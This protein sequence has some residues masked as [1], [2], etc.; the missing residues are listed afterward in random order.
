MAEKEVSQMFRELNLDSDPKDI[1]IG[2]FKE[3][4]YG[5]GRYGVKGRHK[6]EL[7]SA[8]ADS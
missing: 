4:V 5:S 3:F 6:K 8:S 2:E 1:N 7:I